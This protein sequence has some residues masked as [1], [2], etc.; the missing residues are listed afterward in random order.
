MK[1]NPKEYRETMHV[2]K[3]MQFLLDNLSEEELVLLPHDTNGFI[4]ISKLLFESKLYQD[5]IESWFTVA[6]S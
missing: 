6:G 1:N 2:I 3:F 5:Y 4:D